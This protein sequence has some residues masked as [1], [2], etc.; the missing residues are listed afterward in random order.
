VAAVMASVGKKQLAA[1][2]PLPTTTQT[3]KEDAQWVKAQ[4]S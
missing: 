3:L 4:T 1:A 2:R